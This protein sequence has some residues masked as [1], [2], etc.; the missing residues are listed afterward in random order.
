MFADEEILEM[1]EV[2]QDVDKFIDP[3]ME[4]LAEKYEEEDGFVG[5]F[6]GTYVML[7]IVNEYEDVIS[8][9]LLEKTKQLFTEMRTDSYGKKK[10]KN[11][12]NPLAI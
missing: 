2:I 4:Y 3:L 6:I 1:T 7:R 10:G 9:G 5:R 11:K 12:K 8:L